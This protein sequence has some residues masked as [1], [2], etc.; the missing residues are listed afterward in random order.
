MLRIA[1]ATL[2]TLVIAPGLNGQDAKKDSP[3]AQYQALVNEFRQAQ[4][5]LSAAYRAAKTPVEQNALRRQM[6]TIGVSYTPRFMKLAKDHSDDPV[7]FDALS[8][9][10]TGANRFGGKEAG[11]ALELIAKNHIDDKRL[12]QIS[13]RIRMSSLPQVP[14]FL[15]TVLEKSPHREVRGQACYSLATQLKRS[16]A[17][18]PENQA[19][20]ENLFERITKEFADV[21]SRTRTLG[22][23]AKAE[24]FEVR[25]LGIGKTAPDI[26][27]TDLDGKK[28]KLSDYRGKVVVIDFWG[29]W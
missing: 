10:V 23:L 5:D 19:R 3:R 7:A 25:N 16:A 15:E 29:H 27:G 28:F 14:M 12:A 2:V 21:P 6:S 13:E 11:E 4:Q 26:V 9:V 20:A 22:T 17:R 18:N 24:L 1:M 8:W